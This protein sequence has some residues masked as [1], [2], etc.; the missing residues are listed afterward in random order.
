V[1]VV[2]AVAIERT[3]EQHPR[4]IA[5]PS[6]SSKNSPVALPI[7]YFSVSHFVAF[8]PFEHNALAV[9]VSPEDFPFVTDKRGLTPSSARSH[10]AT[11]SRKIYPSHDLE[12]DGSSC[13]RPKMKC[14]C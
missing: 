9:F 5:T 1:A 10:S 7:K 2:V 13:S 12:E 11:S 14:W 3:A 6:A 4:E 8:L